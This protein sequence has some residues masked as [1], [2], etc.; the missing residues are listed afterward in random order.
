MWSKLVVHHN[1]GDLVLQDATEFI[2]EEGYRYV[3]GICIGG[4]QTSRLFHATSYQP[5]KTGIEMTWCIGSSQVWESSMEKGR[6]EVNAL[7]Y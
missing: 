7:F 5:F 2:T 1:H 3:K 6:F 4:G